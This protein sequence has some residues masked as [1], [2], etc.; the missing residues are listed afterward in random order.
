[1]R[2]I[3]VIA[4]AMILA[5]G[6]SSGNVQAQETEQDGTIFTVPLAQRTH[7]RDIFSA[8]DKVGNLGWSVIIPGFDTTQ[9][10]TVHSDLLSAYEVEKEYESA[11]EVPLVIVNSF[12]NQYDDNLNNRVRVKCFQINFDLTTTRYRE[13]EVYETQ[14]CMENEWAHELMQDILR[15]VQI[16]TALHLRPAK[17]EK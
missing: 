7:L 8:I 15:K 11:A 5:L 2:Q 1:M 16:E 6:T 10:I 3:A 13:L 12:V 4:V 14:E 9:R 17:D